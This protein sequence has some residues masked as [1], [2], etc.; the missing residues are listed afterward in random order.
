MRG[1]FNRVFEKLRFL[2]LFEKSSFKLQLPYSVASVFIINYF[3]SAILSYSISFGCA[4]LKLLEGQ[5]L[6]DKQRIQID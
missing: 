4:T 3:F 2:G 5:S 1:F 6:L